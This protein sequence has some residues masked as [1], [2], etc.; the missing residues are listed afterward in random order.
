MQRSRV[1]AWVAAA[2][3]RHPAV[4]LAVISAAFFY[5]AAVRAAAKPFW[6]DEIYTILL[7]GLP[8]MSAMWSAMGDGVDLAPPLTALLTRALRSWVGVGH[9]AT[10]LVPMIAFG[11]MT[12]VL[13]AFVRRRANGTAAVIAALFPFVT[14]AYRHSYEARAYALMMA[15][16]AA[17]LFAWGEAAAGRRRTTN[18]VLLAAAL[19][20][21]LWNHYYAVLAYVP[22]AAGEIVRVGQTRKLDRG[23]LLAVAA[24]LLAALPM[25]PL[26]S[27]ASKQRGTFWSPA[28]V[29][30]IDDTYYF[31]LEPLL[32]ERFAVATAVVL[33][34]VAISFVRRHKEH[35]PPPPRL[36]L[37]ETVAIAAAVLVPAAGV[38]LG[39]LVTGVFV[40][41]YALPGIVGFSLAAALVLPRATWAELAVSVALVVSVAELL[42]PVAAVA[43]PFEARPLLV[44][45]LKS[46]GPTAITGGLTFLQLWYYAD[47]QQKSRLVYVADPASARRYVRTDTIDLGLLALSRWTAVNAV[48]LDSFI[49]Q[50]RQFRLYAYGSGWLLDKLRDSNASLQEVDVEASARLYVVRLDPNHRSSHLWKGGA[51]P[52]ILDPKCSTSF[53]AAPISFSARSAAMIRRATKSSLQN[54]NEPNGVSS[55]PHPRLHTTAGYSSRRRSSPKD[56]GGRTVGTD[57]R[58]RTLLPFVLR[59]R[60]SPAVASPPVPCPTRHSNLFYL[61]H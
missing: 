36:P 42:A 47:P 1:A 32:N 55:S 18:L 7:T 19:A 8:S 34:L 59:N 44:T 27:A 24:S 52:P 20:A 21:G 33:L 29:G 57:A 61:R 25:V 53:N 15:L 45:A 9:V 49:Q 5:S 60:T 16:F 11:T 22:I 38:L 23:V 54:P 43:Q 37:H 56:G 39:V 3:D 10:R 14:A 12:I 28:F 31:L 13:F 51:I 26:L 6:H 30:Q 4:I 40:P 17:A 58:P 35:R 2:L 41:R 50:H 48:P 46:P